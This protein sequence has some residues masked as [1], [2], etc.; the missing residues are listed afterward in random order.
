MAAGADQAVEIGLV[1]A[2]RYQLGAI[3]EPQGEHA[4]ASGDLPD[5]PDV[6][7]RMDQYLTDFDAARSGSPDPK[8]LIA[9]MTEKCPSY[10][11]R[12]L[13]GYSAQMAYKQ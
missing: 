1:V 3:P 8:G 10:P 5:S 7:R 2:A 12:G 13:L 4:L 9:A 6:L 11:E